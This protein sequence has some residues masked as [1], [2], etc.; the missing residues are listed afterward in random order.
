MAKRKKE[1]DTPASSE[2]PAPKADWTNTLEAS[3]HM[4]L[5]VAAVLLCVT[6]SLFVVVIVV[7]LYTDGPMAALHAIGKLWWLLILC[8]V[9]MAYV[10]KKRGL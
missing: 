10:W 6:G 9:A 4:Y 1:R 7:L 3:A 5:F 2:Q 8:F